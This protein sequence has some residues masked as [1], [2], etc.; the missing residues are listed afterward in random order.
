MA[1]KVLDEVGPEPAWPTNQERLA[2]QEKYI[3][4][5]RV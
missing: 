3:Y 1:C 2:A 5:L 4:Y